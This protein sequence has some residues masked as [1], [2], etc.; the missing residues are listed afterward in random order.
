MT[1]KGGS[2]PTLAPPDGRGA[3]TASPE[4]MLVAYL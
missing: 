2:C 3:L 1:T 4:E